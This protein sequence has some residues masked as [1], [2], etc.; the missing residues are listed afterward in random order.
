MLEVV[1]HGGPGHGGVRVVVQL[2]HVPRGRRVAQ[3][4]AAGERHRARHTEVAVLTQ[5]EGVDLEAALEVAAQR[6]LGL[7]GR[8]AGRRRRG[9]C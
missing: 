8:R 7:R 9:P 6:G 3:G 2:A 1:E 5:V 4:P